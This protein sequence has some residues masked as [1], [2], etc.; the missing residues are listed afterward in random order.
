[1]TAVEMALALAVIGSVATGLF[2][3]HRLAIRRAKEL[4]LQADLQTLRA[5]V[6]FFEARRGT[7][8]ATLEETA[9]LPIGRMAERGRPGIWSLRDKG[10]ALNDVFGTPYRYDRATG[11][12]WSGTTGYEHW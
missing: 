6:S 12:V 10:Q 1:M 5:A 2:A 8:P 4:A 3:S 11:R 7:R 9:A